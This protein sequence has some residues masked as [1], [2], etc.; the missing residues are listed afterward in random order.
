MKRVLA[1]S[2]VLAVAGCDDDADADAGPGG[3]AG[4]TIDAG[5]G[6]DAGPGETDLALEGL[7]GP[8]EVLIDDRGM[9]HIY[10]TTVNDL[11]L[12]NGYVMARDR[13]IQMEFLRRLATGRLAAVLGNFDASLVE[14]D[15]DFRFL[16]FRR[17]AQQTYDGLAADD[18]TKV[19]VDA[20]VAGIN[21]YIAQVIEDPGYQPPAGLE[22]FNAI[23]AADDFGPWD[24]VDVLAL[25]RFQSWNLSYDA[26]ADTA[27][28][29]RLM[30]T[31]AAF[32]A[33][34]DLDGPTGPMLSDPRL[35]DRVGLY[36]DF[37]SEVQARRVYSRDGFN[38]GTTM[39]IRPAS[40]LPA[41]VPQVVMPPLET[42][43]AGR[44]FFERL[45]N[46]RFNVRDPHMGSNSWV[47]A[48]EHT[49]NGNAIL[50]NDPHLA[51]PAPGVWWYVHLNTAEMGGEEDFDVQGVGFAALPGVVLGYNRN[52]AWSATTTGYDATDVYAE[53]VTFRNDGT[54]A[55]P[56]WTPVSVLFNGTQVAL[57]SVTERILNAGGEDEDFVIYQ[58]PHHGNIIAESITPPELPVDNGMTAVGSALS[59][60]YTGDE[61]SNELAFF[62]GLWTAED[63]DEALLA[64]DNFQVGAQNFSFVT[65]DSIA[66]STRSRI[67]IRAAAAC[68]FRV[69]PDGQI[70]GVSP[71]FV[72][73]GQ[74]GFEWEGNLP[75]AAIPHDID[76]ARGY[77]ANA[78]QDNVGVTEDGN[79]CND[80][81]YLGGGFA[82]GYRMGRIVERLDEEIAAGDI[83]T[84]E[85]IAL[86]AETRSSLGSTLRDPIVASLTQ[87]LTDPSGDPALRA[88]VTAAGP[89]R[90]RDVED[91]RD[92]L[93][94]WSLETPHGVGATDPDEVAD[95]I[96][97][98]I[99]NAA[100]IRIANLAFGDEERRI[101]RGMNS[102]AR[103][104]MLEWAMRPAAEQ[105]GFLYTYRE[106]YIG[107][108]GWNDTVVWDD[109][110][111]ELLT[112]TRNERVLSGVLEALDWLEGELGSDLE[113]WRWGRLHAVRF[114]QVVPPVADP[115]IVSI[116][117]VG[118]EQ[119]PIGFPRHGDYGAVDVG[120]FSTSN[121]T[122]FTFG[123]GASQRVVV[124][125]TPDGPAAFN[126]LPGG[127]HEDP[128]SPHHA[129]EAE[130]WRVNE[131]P[132]LYFDRADVEAAMES[133]LEFVP[134]S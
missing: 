113:Q 15:R 68:S 104:R 37:F 7:D 38:D 28:T 77:I 132:P 46:H 115:G 53:Q 73:P 71:L 86:Q 10:A 89:D 106:R 102:Q 131:Q 31:R 14:G 3:D 133:R 19:Y 41:Q 27:R 134:A 125:M 17:V 111:T 124:E 26:G 56:D 64:L 123:S 63:I 59:V 30:G 6:G 122:R 82:V 103:P 70:S 98:T 105:D 80:A 83:T 121:G 108:N 50:A 99:F 23:R 55:A 4:P 48:A 52:L 24:P 87:A 96:A 81:Y 97:T 119:F 84:A 9:P 69:E 25:A 43:R 1:L 49:A 128:A 29:E 92:R 39:A 20:F 126:A 75:D 35:A 95:S 110:D 42:V 109:L 45:D 34:G 76:P 120:N 117:P 78:N 22:L 74:G 130:L 60:R 94:A 2:L 118:S 100:W 112:E 51:L 62:S 88:V 91:V 13:F 127:Q 36:A 90:M 61:P 54:L 12:V 47:V 85:M 101:G 8:V 114:D 33:D 107:I 5:P 67:P 93:M 79:P 65:Q 16:G 21:Q 40:G 18:R 32:P 129:D 58:V 72:L 44:R 116:P 11:A 57:E 66:W